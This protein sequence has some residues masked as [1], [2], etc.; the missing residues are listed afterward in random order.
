MKGSIV[1]KKCF[2]KDFSPFYTYII[3]HKNTFVKHFLQFCVIF[4]YSVGA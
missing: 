4:F 3:A 2:K 1:C